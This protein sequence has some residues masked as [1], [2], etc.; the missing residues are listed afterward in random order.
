MYLLQNLDRT[1]IQCTN[2]MPKGWRGYVSGQEFYFDITTGLVKYM[3]ENVFKTDENIYLIMYSKY[4]HKIYV[5][6]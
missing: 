4:I 3:L 2:V 6:Q 5:L 1:Q